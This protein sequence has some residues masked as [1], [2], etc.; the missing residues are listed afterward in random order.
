MRNVVLIIVGLVLISC[1]TNKNSLLVAV[2]ANAQFTL[3]ELVKEFNKTNPVDID[4]IVCSSG[5]LTSQIIAGAPYHMF[6]SADMKYPEEIYKNGITKSKPKIYAK[7]VLIKWSILRKDS[8]YFN[9]ENQNTVAKI[10]IANP[11]NAPYGVAAKEF[12]LK[13]NL[14]EILESKLVYGE[15]IS[16]TNHYI[17]S[18]AV[19]YGFT[20]KSVLFTNNYKANSIWQEVDPDMY[21]PIYQGII[22]IDEENKD[23]KNFYDFVFS[24]TGKK[25]IQ[26]FG[27]I[28][29]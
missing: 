29:D 22:L 15:S 25:I 13:S 16:Q 24:E 6:F 1:G 27:Y 21:S 7:G 12:L 10:A 5:N 20:S 28:T 4:L 17:T 23:A 11:D 14:Y 26:S 18:G 2:S 9:I 3:K 8:S 19:D